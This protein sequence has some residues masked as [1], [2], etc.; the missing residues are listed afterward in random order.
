MTPDRLYTTSVFEELREC[1][2][3]EL[4]LLEEVYRLFQ[5]RAAAGN[6][7]FA[8][9]R[10]S[11]KNKGISHTLSA[12]V[13]FGDWR[14]GF[15]QKGSPLVFLMAFKA[16]DTFFD[17]I[18]EHNPPAGK[19]KK[20]RQYEDKL[21]E[22]GR[23]VNPVLYPEPLNSAQWIVGTLLAL[24]KKLYP[25][26][27]T[28]AHRG[29]FSVD[30]TGSLTIEREG[31][32]P[33]PIH[34]TPKDLFNLTD[35]LVTTMRCV[36]KDWDFGRIQEKRLRYTSD[37]LAEFHGLPILGQKPPMLVNLYYVVPLEDGALIDKSPVSEWVYGRYSGSYDIVLHDLMIVAVGREVAPKSY[38]ISESMFSQLPASFT[39]KDLAQIGVACSMPKRLQLEE[40]R[41]ALYS[42]SSSF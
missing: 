26:R 13:D 30:A 40:E 1:F 33:D 12:S 18:L 42:G 29:Q 37:N 32:N 8:V 11:G 16:V 2:D 24:Y 39:I 5:I 38:Q 6:A 14:P 19:K 28:V 25:Y 4:A 35:F 22:L 21:G 10:A 17:W 20:L 7:E 3:Y 41:Q 36:I 9:I 27:N 34:I 31:P 23:S 15:L